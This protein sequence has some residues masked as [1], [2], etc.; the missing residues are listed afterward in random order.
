VLI[1]R[2]NTGITDDCHIQLFVAKLQ[3]LQI[4]TLLDAAPRRPKGTVL[5]MVD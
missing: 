1:L 3:V 4:R 5:A 2:R